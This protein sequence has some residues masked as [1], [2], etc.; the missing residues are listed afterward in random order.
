MTESSSKLILAFVTLL[1]GVALIGSIASEALG[2]TDKINIADEATNLSVSC[3]DGDQVDETN[4]DC[5]ITV[6]YAPTG[7]KSDD[8]PLTNVVVTNYTGTELTEDTDYV[9]FD[10]TGIIQMLN[11]TETESTNMGDYVLYDYTYCGDDYMNLSWGRTA[12]LL[13]GGFFALGLL[14]T[15]VGLFYSVAKDNGIF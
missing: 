4:A 7:W 1:I 3:Y 15:S 11:T 2:K 9:I 8:C 6:T 10:S 5:N 14:L 12:L 13:V